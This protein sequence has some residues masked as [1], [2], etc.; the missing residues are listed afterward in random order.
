MLLKLDTCYNDKKLDKLQSLN[1]YLHVESKKYCF[2]CPS[3]P[4]TCGNQHNRI[5]VEISH[6]QSH[7]KIIVFSSQQSIIKQNFQP[8]DHVA[9][10]G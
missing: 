5:L 8:I 1:I 9:Y 3:D 10:F 4:M 6:Y 2:W 7:K